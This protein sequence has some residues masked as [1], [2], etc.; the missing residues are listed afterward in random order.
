MAAEIVYNSTTMFSSKTHLLQIALNGSLRD[1]ES[2]I[3]GL[4]ASERIMIEVGTPMIK[5]FGAVAIQRIRAL[6]SIRLA[7][8]GIVQSACIVADMKTMDRG[9]V[10]V[11][12][13][14]EAGAS[15]VIALGQ[16]PIETLNV[17]ISACRR[18]KMTSMVDMMNID[19][20]YQILRKLA[21]LPDVVILHRGVDEERDSDKLLPIYLINKIKGTY[22]VR[23]AIAGG[24]TPREVQSAVFNGADIVI[25]WKD[26]YSAESKNGDITGEFLRTVK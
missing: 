16:A 15:A 10:E 24:D 21:M 6:W 3:A 14:E 7:K 25:L 5:T 11:S 1:A 17:F 26:F 23:V 13:A 4:P 9:A 8:A 22:D 20:P 18:R 2:I 19:K 12:I